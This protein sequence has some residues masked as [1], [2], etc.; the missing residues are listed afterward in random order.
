MLAGIRTGTTVYQAL[1]GDKKFEIVYHT[2]QQVGV[3]EQDITSEWRI[4]DI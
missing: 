1:Y 2:R 4:G 3:G